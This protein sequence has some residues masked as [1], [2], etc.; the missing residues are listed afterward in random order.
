MVSKHAVRGPKRARS[1]TRLF[2]DHFGTIWGLFGQN[3]DFHFSHQN[4]TLGVLAGFKKLGRPGKCRMVAKNWP[5]WVFWVHNQCKKSVR[6]T[7]TCYAQITGSPIF[8]GQ[9]CRLNPQN[10]A[11]LRFSREMWPKRRFFLGQRESL[12]SWFGQ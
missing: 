2:L 8:F 9:K 11:H 1:T 6:T 3:V 12:A 10:P 4:R 5:E 7:P